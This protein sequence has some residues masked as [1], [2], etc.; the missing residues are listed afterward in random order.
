MV[1]IV[2]LLS[3]DLG[4]LQLDLRSRSV[5]ILFKFN[6]NGPILYFYH[7]NN[8]IMSNEGLGSTRSRYKI[9]NLAIVTE[10]LL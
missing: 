4:L 5:H 9:C 2:S 6:L 3:R 7:S 10:I 8:I 1:E